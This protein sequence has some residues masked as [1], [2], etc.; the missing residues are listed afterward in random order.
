MMAQAIVTVL[1]LLIFVGYAVFFA[2]WN[3]GTIPVVGYY[4]TEAMSGGAQVPVFVL[5]LA[6]VLIGAIIMAIAISTPWSS[7]KS[8][9]AAVQN[10]LEAE[11]SRSQERG[12]R[13]EQ[14]KSRLQ[15]LEARTPSASDTVDGEDLAP[16]D[17]D[18]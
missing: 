15:K 2:L 13:I 5:P 14:L 12:R 9:L 6:G 7:L 18:A 8:R 4:V 16:P 3:P 17:E 10:Q 11:R 1:I